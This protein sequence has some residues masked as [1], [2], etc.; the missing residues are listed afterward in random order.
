M[1][2]SKCCIF[3]KILN[4][5][6]FWR[7][8]YFDLETHFKFSISSFQEMVVIHNQR[9][10]EERYLTFVEE[11]F[12]YV[13]NEVD[14]QCLIL[15][16]FV[17]FCSFLLRSEMIIRSLMRKLILKINSITM[18]WRHCFPQ[19]W[20]LENVGLLQWV[21]SCRRVSSSAFPLPLPHSGFPGIRID[22]PSVCP[23]PLHLCSSLN[24]LCI[25]NSS[26]VLPKTLYS[27]FGLGRLQRVARR[28]VHG[29][30]NHILHLSYYLF[31]I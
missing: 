16:K 10:L 17:H 23:L 6:N 1:P 21:M 29:L 24:P 11:N 30:F 13:N 19:V 28:V 12:R 7:S 2:Q 20:R 5:A 14:F 9:K 15:F 27:L 26:G 31:V 3:E 18:Q 22:P 25:L 4:N 8:T